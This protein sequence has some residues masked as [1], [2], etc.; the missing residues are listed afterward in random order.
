MISSSL[1]VDMFC[2]AVC[3]AVSTG[4]VFR[5]PAENPLLPDDGRRHAQQHPSS[6]LAYLRELP[7][8]SPPPFIS[9]ARKGTSSFHA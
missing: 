3:A 1:I 2:R 4:M 9:S 6:I 8:A 7:Q 5:R